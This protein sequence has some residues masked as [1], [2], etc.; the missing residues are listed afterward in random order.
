MTVLRIDHVQLPYPPGGEPAARHFYGEVLGFTEVPKPE[1]MRARGGLWFEAGAV[2]IHLGVEP[3][4]KPSLK[5]HP[6][7]VV[8]DL[9]GYVARLVAAGCEWK[10]SDELSDRR[11]HTRD[12]FGN[13]I[14]LIEASA[15]DTPPAR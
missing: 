6:A 3:E 11:G 14:E 2:A 4:M 15:R 5:M 7:L 12:P 1:V 13:R 8:R 9:E 10:P